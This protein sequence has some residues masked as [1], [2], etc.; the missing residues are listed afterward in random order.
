MSRYG[1]F[2]P[3]ARAAEL[4]GGR[5]TFLIVRELLSGSQHFNDIHRGLP[6]MSRTLLSRRLDMLIESGVVKRFSEGGRTRYELTEAG[7]ELQPML[8]LLGAWGKRWLDGAVDGDELDPSLLLW[9]LRRTTRG[10]GLDDRAVRL[11]FDFSDFPEIQHNRWIVQPDGTIETR[12]DGADGP[13]GVDDLTIRADASHLAEIWIGWRALGEEIDSGRVEVRGDE[14]LAR[15]FRDW[16]G[17][18]PYVPDDSP[19]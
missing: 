18:S 3:V 9:E 14:A 8:E 6:K 13:E 4:F 17:R 19:N 16:L 2:C 10:R 11:R 1:Q 12:S 15:R 5:W 7:L